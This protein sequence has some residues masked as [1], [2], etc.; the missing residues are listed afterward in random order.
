MD[1]ISNFI[2]KLKNAGHAH[3]DEVVVPYSNLKAAIC[4][5]LKSEGF[6][7]GFEEKL[8]GG[9]KNLHISLLAESRVPKI[10]GVQRLSKPSKRVY[11]KASEIRAV[12]NGYGALIV[13]TSGG[14]MTGRAAK[15]AKLGGEALFSIW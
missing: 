15:K 2:I 13:S 12:K 4:A 14:I 7:K 5:V 9:K 11:K 6:I 3:H 1:T 10:K 8:A